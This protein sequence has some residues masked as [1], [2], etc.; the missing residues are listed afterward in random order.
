MVI[1]LMPVIA[2]C[3]KSDDSDIPNVA[4]DLYIPLALPEYSTLN[5]VG[6]HVMVAGGYKGIII[7]RKSIDAFAAYERAC[8]FD[9]QAS[10]SIIEPDSSLVIGIDHKCGSRFNFFDGSVLN[11]PATR[12]MKQYN[13]TYD[14]TTMSLRIFN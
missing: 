4:V 11:A 14:A 2:A 9:P 8:S 12:P 5:S 6:N 1:W 13:C 7:F 10:G 3:N